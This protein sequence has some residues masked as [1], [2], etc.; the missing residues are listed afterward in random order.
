MNNQ[1]F[2]GISMLLVLVISPLSLA[3]ASTSSNSEG[4]DSDDFLSIEKPQLMLTQMK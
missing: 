4:E 2:V 3:F 1:L